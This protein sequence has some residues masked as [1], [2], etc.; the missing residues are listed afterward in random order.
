MSYDPLQD[1]ALE[2]YLDYVDGC[3]LVRPALA[4]IHML[5]TMLAVYVTTSDVKVHGTVSEVLQRARE[6]AERL[7]SDPE[8]KF[9][10]RQVDAPHNNPE[11]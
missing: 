1:M 5:E 7:S 10:I 6:G 4:Y 9:S 11:T 8:A 2:A 3:P